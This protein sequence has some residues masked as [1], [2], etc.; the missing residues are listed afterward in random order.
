MLLWPHQLGGDGEAGAVLLGQ[1]NFD[2][3]GALD[4]LQGSGQV[5]RSH[6]QT[7]LI[8]LTGHALHLVL[9]KEVG[10]QE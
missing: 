4:R 8:V 3:L 6:L 1:L 2:R 9:I 7:N 5:L 10:L